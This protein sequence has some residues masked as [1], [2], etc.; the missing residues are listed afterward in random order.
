MWNLITQVLTSRP[1]IRYSSK[2]NLSGSLEQAQ[3]TTLDF[4]VTRFAHKSINTK[5]FRIDNFFN[6]LDKINQ[7]SPLY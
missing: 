6:G 5:K 3:S 4:W 2:A 1:L 7:S